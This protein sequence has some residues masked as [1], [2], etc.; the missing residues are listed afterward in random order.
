MG[1]PFQPWRAALQPAS[2][3]GYGFKVESGGQTGGRRLAVHEYPK[4]DTPYAEDMGRR[5][6]RW[7]I[8]G[9]CI[10]PDYLS[11]RDALIAALD[12]EGPSTLIHPTLGDNQATCEAYSVTEVRERGGYCV[13]EMTFVEAGED[14]GSAPADDTAAQASTAADKS[15]G[16]A[17]TAIDSGLSGQT[18][19]GVG[20]INAGAGS[21]D[22]LDGSN[23][24]MGGYP[25]DINPGLKTGSNGLVV[26][27]V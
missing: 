4:R 2:Y 19:G 5:A 26:V 7:P 27:G 8:T 23:G 6:H 10:G 25:G 3:A 13:F 21:G 24:V 22:P 17:A 9:Y 16:T 11:D 15:N 18:G 20:G 14:P 1:L 12:A